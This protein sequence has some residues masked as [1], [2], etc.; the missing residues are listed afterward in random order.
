MYGEQPPSYPGVDAMMV[1]G[2][3]GMVAGDVAGGT[4]TVTADS[5]K[6]KKKKKTLK[7]KGDNLAQTI[8][9][10]SLE[11]VTVSV[12]P[13]THPTFAPVVDPPPPPPPPICCVY[14][15]NSTVDAEANMPKIFQND[16]P[17]TCP[18]SLQKKKSARERERE[19]SL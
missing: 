13:S 2:S 14:T 8:Q 4:G 15:Q 12:L 19:G 10:G 9:D 17:S 11:W 18:P 5:E 1:G 3:M 7:K 6:K 16:P